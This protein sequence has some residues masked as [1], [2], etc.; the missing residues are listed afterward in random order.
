MLKITSIAAEG[1]AV[2]LRLDGALSGP[3]VEE[4]RR[5]CEARLVED[6]ALVLD[7][8]GL[9]FVDANGVTLMRS[10]SA[11]QVSLMDCSPFLALQL[12]ETPAR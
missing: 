12:K 10:L 4:L 1:K 7:C 5:L 6:G 8:A 9:S 11:Q 2:R 3:W